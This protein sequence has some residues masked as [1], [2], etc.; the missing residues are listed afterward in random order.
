MLFV[1]CLNE[2]DR[3]DFD[4]VYYFYELIAM[5]VYLRNFWERLRTSYWF[6]P[7]S[8]MFLAAGLSFLI[9]EIDKSV[10][11]DQVIGLG[12]IYFTDADGARAL[13][14]TIAGSMITVAGVVFS[15]TIVVLTLTSSQ[16]GPRLLRNFMQDKGNQFVLG[17]FTATYLYC[18]LVLQRIAG[19]DNGQ[20]VPHLATTFGVLLAIVSL[21]VLIYY[22]HHTS[23]SIQADRVIDKV[24]R[25]LHD[26]II[27][28]F[29]N[30]IGN[31]AAT[32]DPAL[33]PDMPLI[34]FP[35]QSIAIPIKRNGYLQAINEQ[36]LIA[37]ARRYEIVIYVPH[38]PG[39]HLVPGATLAQ[40]WPIE[41][42][43][44][45]LVDVINRS[46]IFG[47]QP[48][49]EQDAEFAIGQ[50]VEVAVRA[51]SPGINDPFTAITCIDHLTRG[52]AVLAGRQFPSPYHYDEEHR[53]R[54]ITHALTFPD[55]VDA[56]FNQIRQYGGN[57]V[58]VAIRL[59]ESIA[60]I[61]PLV[62]READRRALALHAT[63]VT[64][65]SLR[66]ISENYDRDALSSRYE[67]IGLFDSIIEK[68]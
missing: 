63:M 23:A 68:R 66:H 62:Q 39:R 59:L 42:T 34:D 22:I 56:A 41:G 33:G 2:L 58:A 4:E 54:L 16:F 35:N 60:T 1:F 30:K 49:P 7:T 19:I 50:L 29:P 37:I 43:E 48:T 8:M 18:L 15:I 57:S 55:I 40:V 26:T 11:L 51:L 31:H 24:S 3:L 17:T 38:R 67:V 12:W 52:L 14:S 46:F 10:R 44:Q 13:L 27:R 5:R 6:I 65:E 28:L 21:F 32:T 45:D 9:L 64:E 20:F 47:S 36:R 53:L 61:T 25:E